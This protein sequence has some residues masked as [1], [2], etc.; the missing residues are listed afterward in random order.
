[1]LC[2][3]ACESWLTLAVS[4]GE[5]HRAP[6]VC[7]CHT[8]LFPANSS[9][10]SGVTCP[11]HMISSGKTANPGGWGRLGYASVCL[12][13]IVSEAVQ[14]PPV[15]SAQGIP[16]HCQ[17]NTA[18]QPWLRWNAKGGRKAGE[19][20]HRFSELFS[21][22]THSKK[23]KNKTKTQTCRSHL[24]GPEHLPAEGEEKP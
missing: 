1:M 6:K 20:E 12:Q 4:L 5:I 24:Q 23:T 10:E 18:L 2:Q 19:K 11:K 7:T 16:Q 8:P 22:H 15:L 17:K 9:K 13:W 3:K 21:Q 14:R